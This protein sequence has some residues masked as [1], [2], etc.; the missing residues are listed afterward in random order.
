MC[1]CDVLL[2]TYDPAMM[3]RDAAVSIHPSCSAPTGTLQSAGVGAGV[4]EKG[5]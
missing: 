2:Y 4:G 1:V 5:F 3:F